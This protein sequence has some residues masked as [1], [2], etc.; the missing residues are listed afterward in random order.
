[1]AF[2]GE[3][4]Q[5]QALVDGTEDDFQPAL[6]QATE[7]GVCFLVKFACKH[8]S[9]CPFGSGLESLII[10]IPFSAAAGPSRVKLSPS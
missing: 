1:V 9:R 10:R 3:Y 8:I 5:D 6:E 7:E 2:H 4:H